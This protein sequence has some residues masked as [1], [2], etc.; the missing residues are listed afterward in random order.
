M[1][2]ASLLPWSEGTL[3]QSTE[4]GTAMTEDCGAKTQ[5]GKFPNKVMKEETI[6][7]MAVDSVMTEDKR[8]RGQGRREDTKRLEVKEETK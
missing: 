8:Q 1:T 7:L 2:S 3:D 5:S 6:E 4:M